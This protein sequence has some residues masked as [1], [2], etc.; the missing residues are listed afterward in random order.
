[1]VFYDLAIP[2]CPICH[3]SNEAAATPNIAPAKLRSVVTVSHAYSISVM[4]D[5]H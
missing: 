1:M 2:Q 5:L 3:Q 4:V